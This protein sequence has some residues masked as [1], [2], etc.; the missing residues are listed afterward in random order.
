MN[1]IIPWTIICNMDCNELYVVAFGSLLCIKLDL[2]EFGLFRCLLW[3]VGSNC[4]LYLLLYMCYGYTNIF[5]IA[6][7]S[8]Y[9]QSAANFFITTLF[10]GVVCSP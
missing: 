9:K 7:C 1:F 10:H 5:V 4:V 3:S 8:K 2:Y 6:N